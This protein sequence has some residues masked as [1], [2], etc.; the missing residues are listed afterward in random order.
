MAYTPPGGLQA[1]WAGNRG[2]ATTTFTPPTVCLSTTSVLILGI[3]EP[4]PQQGIYYYIGFWTQA[5]PD[6]LTFSD[7]CMPPIATPINIGPWYYS[8][9]I[10]PSA[11]TPAGQLLTIPNICHSEAALAESVTA[12]VCCPP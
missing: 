3:D 9:G 7:P 8:P 5:G 11:Y 1:C 4:P 10:C 2:P 12:W 6:E